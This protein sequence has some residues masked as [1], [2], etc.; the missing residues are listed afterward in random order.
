MAPLEREVARIANIVD[1]KA[2]PTPAPLSKPTQPR[3]K[4]TGGPARRST[5]LT[6]SPPRVTVGRP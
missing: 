5:P 3:A 1:G 2:R 4:A 6:P